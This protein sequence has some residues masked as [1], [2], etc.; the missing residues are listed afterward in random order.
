MENRKKI[1][2]TLSFALALILL[3]ASVYAVD[4]FIRESHKKT[5]ATDVLEIDTDE[6]Y[7]KSYS[8]PAGDTDET[9]VT[10][11]RTHDAGANVKITHFDLLVFSK[12]P[13]KS[14]TGA[15]KFAVGDGTDEGAFCYIFE[16]VAIS[17][18]SAAAAVT[19]KSENSFK[20]AAI[21]SKTTAGTLPNKYVKSF[22]DLKKVNNE[23]HYNEN[24]TV[25]LLSGSYADIYFIGSFS[26]TEPLIITMPFY[27][28]MLYSEL[29]LKA[30][31][32]IEHNFG[33]LYSIDTI[34]GSIKSDSG[35]KLT[36]A[37]PSA[38]YKTGA[39]VNAGVLEKTDF[40]GEWTVEMSDALIDD[41]LVFALGRV[42]QYVFSGVSLP[43]KYQNYL[44]VIS[45]TSDSA[46][47]SIG[48]TVQRGAESSPVNL[49]AKA[50]FKGREKSR[51]KS[52]T[53]VGT[54]IEA[55]GAALSGIV[56]KEVEINFLP[57]GG[58]I[59][60][61]DRNMDISGLLSDVLIDSGLDNII[62]KTVSGAEFRYESV[63]KS[64][65]ELINIS[66]NNDK[67]KDKDKAIELN[68]NG[69]AAELIS[70]DVVYVSPI[71]GASKFILDFWLNKDDS[72][73][74]RDARIEFDVGLKIEDLIKL[75]ERHMVTPYITSVTD[76]IP[77]Y[78]LD[79]GIIKN[80]DD[81][82]FNAYAVSAVTGLSQG[83]IKLSTEEYAALTGGTA[84]IDSLIALHSGNADT[85]FVF[86]NDTHELYAPVSFEDKTN[87]YVYYNK[88]EFFES[89][90]P[91]FAKYT[92]Y[93][94]IVIPD[95][96]IS[97][98][99]EYEEYRNGNTFGGKFDA[100]DRVISG[101]QIGVLQTTDLSVFMNLRFITSAGETTTHAF[102]KFKTNDNMASQAANPVLFD[103]TEFSGGRIKYK[104]GAG[105]TAFSVI[106]NITSFEFDIDITKIPLTNT[107]VTFEVDFYYVINSTSSYQSI[108]KQRYAFIV[109][110]MYR[111]G[112]DFE[113]E[114]YDYLIYSIEY[115]IARP[116]DYKYAKLN[117]VVTKE[118]LKNYVY[119][120]VAVTDETFENYVYDPSAVK[121]L[122]TDG[123]SLFTVLK[124][125]KSNVNSALGLN[126]SALDIK[127]VNFLLNAGELDFSG[128]TLTDLSPLTRFESVKNLTKLTLSECSLNNAVLGANLMPL[129]S[130]RTVDLSKNRL[131]SL[132]GILY[133]T[134]QILNVSAQRDRD[135]EDN[136]VRT[137]TSIEG[138]KKLYELKEAD[139]SSNGVH[140]FSPL[141]DISRTKNFTLKA[142]KLY[143][144]VS[145][146]E[147]AHPGYFGTT[148][149]AN[150]SV[151]VGLILKKV[152]VYASGSGEILTHNNTLT[153]ESAGQNMLYIN[154]LQWTHSI[155]LNGI[156]YH[157][158]REDIDETICPEPLFDGTGENI[159]YT[160]K[161]TKI[162][163]KSTAGAVSWHIVEIDFKTIHILPIEEP[164][165][166]EEPEE[167][168]EEEEAPEEDIEITGTAAARLFVVYYAA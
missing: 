58:K 160:I 89:T 33:G 23:K 128:F 144:N 56:T 165:E 47:F 50:S 71:T 9:I 84:T 82:A 64:E 1:L 29:D 159:S 127:G 81:P 146:L 34:S 20:A 112:P 117:T 51:V 13:L 140:A 11:K 55:I 151:Y 103:Q 107:T 75:M 7:Y 131:S 3:V 65:F 2:I 155:V 96:G 137:L 101:S 110:G 80:P 27:M 44:A 24:E 125:T 59:R 70:G 154:T 130:L 4:L 36:I 119:N 12:E 108:S 139:I 149:L 87:V 21:P 95:S 69:A 143:D 10:V 135:G 120:P 118:T 39:A 85:N 6:T 37:V 104:N 153:D 68:W 166:E 148:G 106:E 48:G 162:T 60:A 113:T 109:P 111:E 114:L 100:L 115:S 40:E 97:G 31:V 76:R 78:Y 99:D 150:I 93:R 152:D 72:S 52:F 57:E 66:D 5:A 167:E 94:R 122:L 124:A 63:N 86:D 133:R 67:D 28:N 92:A 79:D 168:P 35:S 116:T 25:A 41:M 142:V 134:V 83:V 91:S 88:F 102:C 74:D 14:E 73:S 54:T 30:D 136:E 38:Y 158:T 32:K 49:S 53:V 16:D 123:V 46:A 121:I 61:F 105:L 62:T 157:E 22:F 145:S 43:V 98:G 164:G 163:E 90:S 156:S 141:Y 42:P 129:T 17:D 45:Y 77:V 147:Q 138:L 18:V 8:A 19:V 161:Q 132:D 26:V 15:Q 126:L